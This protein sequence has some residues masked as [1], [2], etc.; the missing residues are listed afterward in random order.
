MK[1][2]LA[3]ILKNCKDLANVMRVSQGGMPRQ[4]KRILWEIECL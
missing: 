1:G 3:I 4:S 2:S